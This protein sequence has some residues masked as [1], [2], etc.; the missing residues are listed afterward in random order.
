MGKFASIRWSRVSTC[1]VLI[2]WATMLLGTHLPAPALPATPYSD[3]SLHFMAYAG[4]GFLLAWA[5][6]T[7]RPFLWGG[8]LFALGVAAGYGVLDELTQSLIPGR[9]AD[10]FDWVYDAAGTLAGIGVFLVA[11]VLARRV[12]RSGKKT[13]GQ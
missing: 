3:K 11:G 6:T 12:F 13:L 5:W 2:Y 10:V 7:R 8:P 1:A 9:S 4:L